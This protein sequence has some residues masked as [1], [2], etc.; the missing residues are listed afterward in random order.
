MPLIGQKTE[1]HRSYPE[2]GQA[3]R[4][5]ADM[6]ESVYKR[7][8]NQEEKEAAREN[9]R[10]CAFSRWLE[11]HRNKQSDQ[12]RWIAHRGARAAS[13][14]SPAPLGAAALIQISR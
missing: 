9:R 8:E 1:R 10:S 11:Q 13:P 6:A 4:E 3:E 5:T 7:A 14:F 2:D 12:Q